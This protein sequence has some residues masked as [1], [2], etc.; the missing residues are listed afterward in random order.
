MNGRE[1][2]PRELELLPAPIRPSALSTPRSETAVVFFS[3]YSKL[4]NHFL[5]DFVIRKKKYHSVEHYLAFRR[6]KLSGKTSMIQQASRCKSPVEAKVVLNLLK[7]DHE[8][9][10]NRDAEKYA[11]EAL[12][13]K[14]TQNSSLRE[15][16]CNTQQLRIGEAS[17]NPRWGI[18]MTLQDQDALDTTKWSTTGNLL[19]RALETVRSELQATNGN[20]IQ[21]IHENRESSSSGTESD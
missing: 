3:K 7:N 14:F 10:W 4:S 13:A 17:K 8:E 11:L 2:S 16:L 1:Y 12:R 19:G 15:Y 20:E 5:S 21:D 18:G 6:A 9:D